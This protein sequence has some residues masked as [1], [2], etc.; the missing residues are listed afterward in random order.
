MLFF[1]KL[2]WDDRY[3]ILPMARLLRTILYR[4]DTFNKVTL[5]SNSMETW[6]YLGKIVH[7]MGP[8]GPSQYKD[9]GLQVSLGLVISGILSL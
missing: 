4:Y 8:W 6:F 7:E 9:V 3:D 2:W 5:N 1:S